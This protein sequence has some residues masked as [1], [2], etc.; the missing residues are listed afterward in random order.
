MGIENA[1]GILKG[2]ITPLIETF[3]GIHAIGI[4]IGIK[5][6]EKM[7]HVFTSLIYVIEAIASKSKGIAQFL[8]LVLSTFDGELNKNGAGVVIGMIDL[9]NLV[10]EFQGEANRVQTSSTE[11]LMVK[12]LF[13]LLALAHKLT[14]VK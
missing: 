6:L 10:L 3:P 1:S 8:S 13:L 14:K 11:K 2:I 7:S 9:F 4:T 12:I 5:V